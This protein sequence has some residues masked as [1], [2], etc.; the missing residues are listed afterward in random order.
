MGGSIDANIKM[1]LC[2][3]ACR[4]APVREQ[5]GIHVRKPKHDLHERQDIFGVTLREGRGRVFRRGEG[6]FRAL[7]RGR[8]QRACDGRRMCGRGDAKSAHG[9][10]GD[11]L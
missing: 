3:V 7:T 5:C 9:R 2:P 6:G 1:A 10:H 4:R 11:D 8:I